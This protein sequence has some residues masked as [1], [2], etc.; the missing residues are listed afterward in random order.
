MPKRSAGIL[1]Y[2][3]D[4]T[5]RRAAARASGRSVLGQEGSWAPGRSRRANMPRARTPLAVAK[6]EFEEETGARPHGDFLPLGEVV[7]PGRKIVTAWAV[8]GDF[9]PRRSSP[10]RSSW[11]GRRRADARLVSRSRP[12]RMV[13]ARRGAAKNSSRAERVHRPAAER[14]STASR[15]SALSVRPS[16]SM[17]SRRR[18]AFGFSTNSR[19]AMRAAPVDMRGPALGDRRREPRAPARQRLVRSGEALEHQQV[20]VLAEP[21][22]Q[23]LRLAGPHLDE[24][25]PQRLDDVHL[26][27]MDH[28]ALAQLVQLLAV[29][30]RPIRRDRG[31]APRDRSA[32]SWSATSSKVKR[33]SGQRSTSGVRLVERAAEAQPHVGIERRLGR[34]ADLLD[35][36]RATPAIERARQR[37]TM[38][39][40]IGERIERRLRVAR[41]RR[42][43]GR[44]RAPRRA[45]AW[46]PRPTNGSSR[47]SS[48][49]QRFIARRKSCTAS[50]S[51]FAGSSI[52]ARASARMSRATARNA[53][54]TATPGRKAGLSFMR[55][56][57]TILFRDGLTKAVAMTADRGDFR[58]G[59]FKPCHDCYI[60]A[61]AGCPA[62]PVFAG[63]TRGG[64]AR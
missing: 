24:A 13:F 9:D 53:S 34:L 22:A 44:G 58:R 41:A 2:R 11:N 40:E 27:A 6:R 57:Y 15:R 4:A 36:R 10:T 32:S 12:R 1:M 18:S 39:F 33:W 47:R 46:P 35:A 8:E 23:P 17:A 59:L 56:N 28:D 61:G 5:P 38:L 16:T 29:G 26:V 31:R 49:R 3:R 42:A 20:L 45:A 51:D 64:A 62:L 25:R 60:S 30:G 43:R 50:A 63:L 48:A 52:A 14:R 55:A 54:P 37:E 21:V 19:A 7:Q